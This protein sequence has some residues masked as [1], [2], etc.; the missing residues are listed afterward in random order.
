[1]NK[2][3]QVLTGGVAICGLIV[4]GNAVAAPAKNKAQNLKKELEGTEAHDSTR[5]H[6]SREGWDLGNG[7]KLNTTGGLS[8]VNP[9]NADYW[10]KLSGV[11]RLDQTLFMGS[12]RD[13]A[14]YQPN[15]AVAGAT[16][17][18][19]SNGGLIRVIET[20]IDGG[21][22]ENWEYTFSLSYGGGQSTKVVI[23][24]TWLSYTGLLENNQVYVGRVPGNWFGLDNANSTSW[25]PF[26]ERS[27]QTNAFYPGD[28]LGVMTDFWWENGGLTLAAFQPNQGDNRAPSVN[29]GANTT[30][31]YGAR[32]RWATTARAT[33]APVHNLGDVWHFGVSGAWREALSSYNGAANNGIGYTGGPAARSRATNPGDGLL[34]TGAIQANNAR[35]FNVEAARQ[36]GSFML[37]GEYTTAFVHRVNNNLGTLRFDGWNV[38]TRYL[39]TGETHA[40]DVRDGNFGTVV[41]NAHYGAFEVVA[42]YDFLNLNNKDVRGG[43]EHN[44]SVGL[45]WF[46]SQQL[47][48]SAN[49]IRASIHPNSD[50][51]KRNLDIVSARLQVRF[52]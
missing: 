47:R 46:I 14:S 52:K 40:Y 12:Y 23:S 43:T 37:E 2:V 44:A 34:S 18:T 11:M 25:N 5:R 20:Y 38:Q 4:G 41:P 8:Y 49:Y 13:K 24:D 42:R 35:L 1:M 33:V 3:S 31:T 45:N 50:Q 51:A 32:D 22:G 39:L 28:G 9:Q 26:L 29:P 30:A 10:V 17:K 21:L 48:L 19:I 7:W 16:P 36:I 6:K 15:G 27:M